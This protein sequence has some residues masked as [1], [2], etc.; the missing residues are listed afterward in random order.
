[1]PRRHPPYRSKRG[2]SACVLRRRGPL[3]R[4]SNT[5]LSLTRR[6]LGLKDPGGRAGQP[7]PSIPPPARTGEVVLKARV[8][9]NPKKPKQ[10]R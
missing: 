10:R 4:S 8:P 1:M 9:S 5:P 2:E 3:G 6:R 7:R